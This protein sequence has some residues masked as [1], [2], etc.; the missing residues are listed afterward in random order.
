[1]LKANTVPDRNLLPHIQGFT[2]NLA[3]KSVYSKIDL[4]K[5]CHQI[6]VNSNNNDNIYL[7]EYELSPEACKA[8]HA[9]TTLFRLFKYVR[10][11]FGLRNALQAYVLST[12]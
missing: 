11:P 2:T 10:I 6:Q 3:G 8:R 5:A 1:M 7:H 4:V 9:I 12:K